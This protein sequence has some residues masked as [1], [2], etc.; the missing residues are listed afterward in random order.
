MAAPAPTLRDVITD[1]RRL[2]ATSC[3]APSGSA[4]PA[5]RCASTTWPGVPSAVPPTS[6]SRVL[7][8]AGGCSAGCAPAQKAAGRGARG[9]EERVGLPL[10]GGGRLNGRHPP[11]QARLVVG[12]VFLWMTPLAAALS[13]RFT[14]RRSAST[15]SSHRT[16]PRPRQT[17]YACVARPAPTCAQPALLVLAVALDLLLMLATCRSSVFFERGVVDRGLTGADDN[18]S[19]WWAQ[20]GWRHTRPGGSTV[21]AGR[22]RPPTWAGTIDGPCRPLSP[23]L[24]PLRS[25]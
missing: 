22:P 20:F 1:H 12:S 13:I 9:S 14:A 24:D 19:R 3:T 6:P 18:C 11:H 25:S 17:S 21:L 15:L 23:Q 7:A 4:P 5:G 2:T 10:L 8:L 16:R